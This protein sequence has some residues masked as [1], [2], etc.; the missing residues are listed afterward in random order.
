MSSTLKKTHKSSMVIGLIREK[1]DLSQ[2]DLAAGA[3]LDRKYI[4]NLE[5]GKSQPTFRSIL[6][7]SKGLRMRPSELVKYM[8][9]S[10]DE[11]EKF[12]KGFE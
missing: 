4:S 10:L 9:E 8:E 2:E 7:L 5:N 1:K 3:Q 11:E 12:W 6:K